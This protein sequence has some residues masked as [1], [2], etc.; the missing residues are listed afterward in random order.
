MTKQEALSRWLAINKENFKKKE[1]DHYGLEVYS[2]GD[3]EYA[4]GTDKEANKACAEYI[5]DSLWAFNASFVAEHT[6]TGYTP[7]LEKSI[8]KIQEQCESAQDAIECMIEDLEEFIKDAISIDGRGHFLSGYDGDE[9]E[10]EDYYI[11]RI[12]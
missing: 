4:I 9:H 12:N 11:Y 8:S 2:L 7:E 5:K 1:Y 3:R 6:K 10:E